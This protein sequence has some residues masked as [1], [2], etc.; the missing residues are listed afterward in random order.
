V[1]ASKKPRR[2]RRIGQTVGNMGS[3]AGDK[4][5]TNTT[6]VEGRSGLEVVDLA[7]VCADREFPVGQDTSG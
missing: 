2:R 3:L 7:D 4:I 1:N 5:S 6:M